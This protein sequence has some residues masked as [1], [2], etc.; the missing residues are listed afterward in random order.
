M[1][2]LSTRAYRDGLLVSRDFPVEDLSEVAAEP[3]TT[4]WVD[5][6]DSDGDLEVLDKLGRELEIG[7]LTIEDAVSRHERPKV[8]HYPGYV[9][10][11]AYAT[12]LDRAAGQLATSEVSAIVTA[13]V[14]VTV[15]AG[16]TVGA[17]TFAERWESQPALLRHGPGAILHGLLD[18]V[19]DG[20]F[21]TVQALD[22]ELD[23]IEELLFDD[24]TQREVQR[25]TFQ[26]RKSLV[27]LRR[28]VLPMRE[29][30][31]TLLRRDLGIVPTEAVPYYQ[32][33]YDHVLR[34][35]EWTESLRDL[36]T[37][38]FETNL[39]LQD[40]RLNQVIKKLTSWAAII[41]VPTA[42]TGFFGQ[43]V[44]FP[45]EGH[46]SGLAISLALIVATASVLYL[47]FRS[48]DW[49]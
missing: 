6:V 44:R 1:T 35:T 37:T 13:R 14:V 30:L 32:D 33:V 22:E 29:V 11:N 49:I 10:V 41:A 23:E 26:L 16:G 38:L 24:R 2:K 3:G 17:D 5:L 7:P 45:G 31:N 47:A 46:W 4:V 36:V 39:S 18:L 27:H 34:V 42:I 9:F 48:R 8:D 28:V 19:V 21:D 12:H 43:N 15:R 40:H 20:H 25:R